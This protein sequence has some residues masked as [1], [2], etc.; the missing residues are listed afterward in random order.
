MAAVAGAPIIAGF[1][2]A[3]AICLVIFGVL[4]VWGPR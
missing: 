1:F 3:A 2:V 4:S